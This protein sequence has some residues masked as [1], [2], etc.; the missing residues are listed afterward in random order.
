MTLS[1]GIDRRQLLTSSVRGAIMKT[2][3]TQD[4]VGAD[5]E[6]THL[7]D[8]HTIWLAYSY[9]VYVMRMDARPA[10]QCAFKVCFYI[11]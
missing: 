7:R 11:H 2:N 5:D 1:R 6:L 10:V 8:D 3:G 9:I 4:V